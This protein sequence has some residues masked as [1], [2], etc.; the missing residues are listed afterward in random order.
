MFPRWLTEL[1]ELFFNVKYEPGKQNVV[2]DV[3]PDAL[4]RI[5]NPAEH[6]PIDNLDEKLYHI[7]MQGENFMQQLREEQAN[8]PIILDAID[9]VRDGVKLS[10]GRFQHIQKQLQRE[11]GILTKSGRPVVPHVHR[12]YVPEKMHGECHIGSEKFYDRISRKF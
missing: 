1:E 7:L 3:V 9:K 4:S 8:D 2:P 10:K 6:D 11:G 12:K 5:I